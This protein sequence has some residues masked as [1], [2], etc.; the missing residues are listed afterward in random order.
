MSTSSTLLLKE[1]SIPPQHDSV[2]SHFEI[3]SG[4]RLNALADEWRTIARGGLY[5][6]PFYQPEWFQAYGTSFLDTQSLA[7][8]TTRRQGALIG[9]IPLTHSRRVLGKVPARTLRSLSGIHSSRFDL[10]HAPHERDVVAHHSWRVMRDQMEWDAVEILDVPDHGSF[11][12]IM[13]LAK[14]DGFLVGLWPT[15]NM[16]IMQISD[17][18]P[19]TFALCPASSRVYRTRL[20]SKHRRLKK[21]GDLKLKAIT[22]HDHR[23][24]ESFFSLE[25]RGWKGRSGSAIARCRRTKTFYEQVAHAASTRGYLR[26]YTLELNDAPISMHF[27]LF[28]NNSYYAPKIAYDETFST[29]SPGQLL[30]KLAIEDLSTHGASRYEFLGP[31]APWKR[32]WTNDCRVHHTCY[33]FRPST[34]GRLLYSAAFRSALQLRAL[35]HLIWG[36]PQA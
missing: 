36:D 23:A 22:T 29:Y 9:I 10:I 7:A 8:I 5:G 30:V 3:Y 17:H 21:N 11:H 19:T 33:I 25:A 31:R 12:A 26:A 18:A 28:M 20:D 16:P 27:G 34:K 1:S 35:K 6:E 4:A 15:R 2:S 24:I 13:Q 32:I 14:E